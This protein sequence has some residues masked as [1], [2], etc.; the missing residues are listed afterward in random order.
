MD[1]GEASPAISMLQQEHLRRV[2]FEYVSA[3]LDVGSAP[4]IELADDPLGV[5]EISLINIES[6][7]TAEQWAAAVGAID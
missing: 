1:L 6:S 3:N 2:L 4:L 7:A 5:S